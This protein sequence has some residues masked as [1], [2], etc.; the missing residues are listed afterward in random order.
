MRLKHHISGWHLKLKEIHP[1]QDSWLDRNSFENVQDSG[2]YL[3][4]GES[5]PLELALCITNFS[6]KL[7]WGER[8]NKRGQIFAVVLWEGF[9][10]TQVLRLGSNSGKL[11]IQETDLLSPPNR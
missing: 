1:H 6:V 8:K 4:E 9:K 3:Q 10:C 11:E 7:H 2:A 5:G